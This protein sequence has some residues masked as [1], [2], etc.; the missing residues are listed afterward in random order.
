[1]RNFIGGE[2]KADRRQPIAKGCSP[3]QVLSSAYDRG[4][5]LRTKGRSKKNLMPSTKKRDVVAFFNAVGHGYPPHAGHQSHD[6][7]LSK[8]IILG[9]A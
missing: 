4:N 7:P 5:S 9:S 3:L 8:P 1:M 6:W 2:R